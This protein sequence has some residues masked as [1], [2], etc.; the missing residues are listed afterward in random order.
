MS[1]ILASGGFLSSVVVPPPLL[2]VLFNIYNLMAAMR[3]TSQNWIKHATIG[4]RQCPG[5]KHPAMLPLQTR[6]RLNDPGDYHC[7]Q[8]RE[9]PKCGRSFLQPENPQQRPGNQDVN[10]AAAFPHPISLI[11][12]N[13]NVNSSYLQLKSYKRQPRNEG[14]LGAKWGRGECA[15]QEIGVC[16]LFRGIRNE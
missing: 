5:W 16:S 1:T 7:R 10:Y 4:R 14:L 12:V 6:R 9:S 15:L 3:R 8:S 11:N 2:L 13:K